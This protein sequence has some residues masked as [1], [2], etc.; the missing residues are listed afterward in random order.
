M[1]AGGSWPLGRPTGRRGS[2]TRRRRCPGG[3]PRS[4]LVLILRCIRASPQPIAVWHRHGRATSRTRTPAST[5]AGRR[6][7]RSNAST[8]PSALRQTQ[9]ESRAG[10][11]ARSLPNHHEGLCATH[12]R[13]RQRASCAQAKME[14]PRRG[15]RRPGDSPNACP[16]SVRRS[17]RLSLA[18][19]C[20]R[21]RHRAAYACSGRGP[22]VR[23]RAIGPRV[24]PASVEKQQ[25]SPPC[26]FPCQAAVPRWALTRAEPLLLSPGRG[27]AVRGP[28]T[29]APRANLR[30]R[31]SP[32]SQRFAAIGSADRVC[33]TTCALAG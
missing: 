20:E 9:G 2:R 32:G 5:G 30:E 6:R 26:C 14:P 24:A 22:G 11:G 19:G 10:C 8:D 23:R 17:P 12:T 33:S 25:R 1:R 16:E 13:R 4:R 21:G 29:S 15:R 18:H 28:V 7:P 27:S 3:R 31:S